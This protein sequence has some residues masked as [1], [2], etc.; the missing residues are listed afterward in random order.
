MPQAALGVM[1]AALGD[2]NFPTHRVGLAA[3]W[4]ASL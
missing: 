3:E 4:R 2:L 1:M